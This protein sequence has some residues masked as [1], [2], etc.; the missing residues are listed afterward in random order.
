MM[1]KS[2]MHDVIINNGYY[3]D[4]K[5]SKKEINIL[6]NIIKLSLLD[7]LKK[8]SKAYKIIKKIDLKNYH[9]YSEIIEHR[10]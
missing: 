8:N 1:K 6:K 7:N 2:I 5:I 9:K 10:E 4:F 3:S